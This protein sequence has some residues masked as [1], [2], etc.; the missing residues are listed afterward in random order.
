MEPTIRSGDLLLLDLAQDR[1]KD[2][3]MYV[4]RGDDG[5]KAK[6]VQ[7]LMDSRVVI[8]SD[9]AAYKEEIVSSDAAATLQIIGRVV[10]AGR[11]LV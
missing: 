4:F 9:N 11:K 8:H 6:R 1:L 2:D 3:A 10:W 5:L 7:R